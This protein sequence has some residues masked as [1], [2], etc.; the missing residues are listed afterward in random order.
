M[1]AGSQL[2]GG[3]RGGLAAVVFTLALGAC[4]KAIE[5]KLLT[6]ATHLPVLFLAYL[7]AIWTVC[8]HIHPTCPHGHVPVAL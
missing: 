4:S 1:V 5:K 7:P 3:G 6:W 2:R 8:R